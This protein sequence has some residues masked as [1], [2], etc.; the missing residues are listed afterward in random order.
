MSSSIRC[1][2][3]PM[4]LLSI[5][6]KTNIGLISAPSLSLNA[7]SVKR[8]CFEDSWNRLEFPSLSIH[9]LKQLSVCDMGVLP[10]NV[11]HLK[12]P[13]AVPFPDRF[14]FTFFQNNKSVLNENFLTLQDKP[15]CTFL[16]VNS[17]QTML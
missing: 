3:V 2:R 14:L 15:V 11:L 8:S 9:F 6:R 13:L 16:E 7:R 17:T 10:K 4:W 5:P 12:T 1:A